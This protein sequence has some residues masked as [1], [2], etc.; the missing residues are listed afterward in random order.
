MSFQINIHHRRSPYLL[1]LTMNARCQCAQISFSTPTP[2]PQALYICHCTECR[3]QS[4]SAFGITAVFP[5]FELP[6]STRDM[7]GSYTR[8]TLK[9]QVKEGLFCRNCGARILH[10]DRSDVPRPGESPAPHATV[11]VR[12]GCLEGLTRD[13]M[14]GAVHIWC[15]EAVVRIPEGV[16]RFDEEPEDC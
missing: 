9:G 10:R 6:P 8:H 14:D 7:L 3:H 16:E 5:Y 1:Q 13:M 12:G 15:K 2:T 11:R 4:S